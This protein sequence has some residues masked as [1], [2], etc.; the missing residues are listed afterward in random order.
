MTDFFLNLQ[1][2]I[3]VSQVIEI[4][5][6]HSLYSCESSFW[7]ILHQTDHKVHQ[8]LIPVLQNLLLL[9]KLHFSKEPT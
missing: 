9:K 5:I 3:L 7:R 4:W 1:K 8:L 6:A 2:F